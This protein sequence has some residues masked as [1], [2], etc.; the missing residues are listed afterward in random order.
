MILP[1]ILPI[2]LLFT[3]IVVATLALV[4]VLLHPRLHYS[5]GN[6]L[7]ASLGG[8]AGL[9][10]SLLVLSFTHYIWGFA[11]LALLVCFSSIVG[12]VAAATI[13]GSRPTVEIPVGTGITPSQGR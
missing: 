8:F 12:A 2:F 3:V 13:C 5:P 6:W 7:I 4:V 11:T 10:V 1:M 9:P